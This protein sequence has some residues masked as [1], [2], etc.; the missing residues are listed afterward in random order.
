MQEPV[1]AGSYARRNGSPLLF[2]YGFTA[3][4]ACCEAIRSKK[5]A[6]RTAGVRARLYVC[7]WFCWWQS[8]FALDP[9]N[10]MRSWVP[11]VPKRTSDKHLHRI[12][13][14]TGAI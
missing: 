1:E 3:R 13:I 10:E 7:C 12:E 6:G 5:I 8:T 11:S 9:V 14:E 2:V 4:C